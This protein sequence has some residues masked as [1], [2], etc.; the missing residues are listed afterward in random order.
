MASSYNIPTSS[1]SKL[2]RYFNARKAAGQIVQPW[3][4]EE[5]YAGELSNLSSQKTANRQL[6]LAEQAQ[7]EQRRANAVTEA[8]NAEKLAEAK[9]EYES[10]LANNQ[11]Q[12]ASTLALQQASLDEQKRATAEN[13]ALAKDQLDAAKSASKVSGIG[14]G[15]MGAAAAEKMGIPVID[16]AKSLTIN[17]LTMGYLKL[18]DAMASPGD[19]STMGDVADTASGESARAIEEWWAN[20]GMATDAGT[21]STVPPS[22]TNET[23]NQM[24][25]M[26][27]AGE[28][29][30]GLYS[31]MG[32]TGESGT[33]GG[34]T[35]TGKL[36]NAGTETAADTAFSGTDTGVG[37]QLAQS[38]S[39]NAGVSL[40]QQPAT[41]PATD[42]SSYDTSIKN[43]AEL[44]TPQTIL[45]P[46][47][48][49]T[50][51]A[52]VAPWSPSELDQMTGME[53]PAEYLGEALPNLASSAASEAAAS[54]VNGKFVPV[55]S[56]EGFWNSDTGHYEPLYNTIDEQ[57]NT[58]LAQGGAPL[59]YGEL[60]YLHSSPGSY[61]TYANAMNEMS[62]EAGSNLAS[63]V[64]DS[65]ADTNY[66]YTGGSGLVSDVPDYTV[67]QGMEGIYAG[68]GGAGEAT[69]GL[70]AGM[71]GAGEAGSA[72][73]SEAA[74]IGLSDFGGFPL[75][76]ATN[77]ARGWGLCIIVTACTDP[78][79]PEV[80]IAREY[81]D[82]HMD[83]DQIRGYYMI[84][85]KVV[86]LIK[87]SDLF[88]K[89]VKRVLVDSLVDYG[90]S[91][92]GKQEAKPRLFSTMVSRAFLWLCGKIGKTRETF[93][94]CNG[95]VV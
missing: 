15:L 86:P 20:K 76:I 66:D 87:Q 47:V 68:M 40:G 72:A 46:N 19:L 6:S 38:S 55:E 65:I 48:S 10:T 95:E 28:P 13:E 57:L 5:A 59:T 82:K 52:T 62:G 70:Y 54:A 51:Q 92:L 41:T 24:Q 8:L 7:A 58:W 71:G 32:G 11:S 63:S 64:L 17:P 74:G 50:A 29:A 69:S 78:H 91:A 45:T 31:G 22:F 89:I 44:S 35:S 4:L 39:T 60:Q 53:A 27:P 83:L 25:G 26:T 30:S 43:V 2:Q 81:R 75:W 37:T 34:A 93:V 73:A 79:S 49:Q 85:E 3:E 12:Y 42:L 1:L 56:G 18:K 84:A 14:T 23:I 88:K 77:I 36:I 21:S 16:T 80:Q 90:K 94:R 9:K 61:V 33:Y 67:D